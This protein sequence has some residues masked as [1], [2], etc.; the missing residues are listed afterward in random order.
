MRYEMFE[1]GFSCTIVSLM[2]YL[3]Q[4]TITSISPIEHAYL[5]DKK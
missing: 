4:H 2:K 5:W 1:V 3:Y